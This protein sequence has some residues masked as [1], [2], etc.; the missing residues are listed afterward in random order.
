MDCLEQDDAVDATRVAVMG[1]S[2]LGKTALWAGAQDERF[3]LAISND[4]GAGG[5]ALARRRFGETVAASNS[6]CPHWFCRN[7]RRYAGAEDD[8][9][10]DQHMLIA[11][12][13]RRPV[14]VASAEEDLWAD[15]RGEFLSALGADP[16]YRLLGTDGMSAVEMPPVEH[17]VMSRVGYHVRL[18]D[19]DVTDYDWGRYLDFADK[20]MR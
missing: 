17:P 20:H 4:S 19:H 13:A 6:M 3:A 7:Y 11:L 8:M 5:A 15:P 1:H 16:V 2:R 12:M 18:G 9:P 14:Y 10:V